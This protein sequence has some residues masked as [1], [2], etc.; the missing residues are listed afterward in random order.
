MIS[1]GDITYE[2][3]NVVTKPEEVIFNGTSIA[4][5]ASDTILDVNL[6]VDGLATI[7][8]GGAI[9]P[10]GI[11]L[12]LLDTE[13]AKI[14]GTFDLIDIDVGPSVNM[15][16]NFELTP[17][18]TVDLQFDKPVNIAGVE[19]TSYSGDWNNLPEMAFF[20][21][22]TVTPTFWLDAYLKNTSGID[23]GL[24]LSLDLLKMSF[25]VKMGGWAPTIGPYQPDWGHISYPLGTRIPWNIFDD[26]PFAFTGFQ[27]IDGTPFTVEVKNSS[28]PVPEPGTLLLMG[29]GL[30]VFGSSCRRRKYGCHAK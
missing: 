18:L 3:P 7:L 5:T 27:S 28:E 13:F 23:L 14:T 29:V 21:T 17:T 30:A 19:T 8:S 4:A 10:T 24:D 1:L 20:E 26:E 2:L 9:P 25:A 11:K 12:N 16:Q 6:D 22:T 15:F